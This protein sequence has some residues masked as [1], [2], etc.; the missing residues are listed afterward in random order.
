[1]DIFDWIAE[2]AAWIAYLDFA[3]V[4]VGFVI[5]GR[6]ELADGI[7]RA[8]VTVRRTVSGTARELANRHARRRERRHAMEIMKLQR[9][10]ILDAARLRELQKD[11]K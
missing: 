4:I 3:A 2:V 7:R 9:R 8:I 10:Q 11:R 6:H 5:I 1:M